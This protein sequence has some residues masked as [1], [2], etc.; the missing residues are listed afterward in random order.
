MPTREAGLLQAVVRAVHKQHP[1]AWQF[2][3]VGSPYQMAGVPDL[4]LC[5]DGLLVGLELKFQRPSESLDHA[6]ARTTPQQRV[7]IARINAAGGIAGTVTTVK[8]ALD[9][10]GRGLRERERH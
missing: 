10:I 3:V 5:V 7:Q 2:K 6:L 1:T 9:L 8:D 4:L